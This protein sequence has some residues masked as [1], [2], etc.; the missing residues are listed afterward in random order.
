M[1]TAIVYGPAGASDNSYVTLAA[2]D[3]WFAASARAGQ[4]SGFS[5][6]ERTNALIEATRNI[7]SL[8]GPKDSMTARRARFGG[9]PAYF[10][11]GLHF[12]RGHDI[13]S[14]G[15]FIVPHGV[16][17]AVCEQA[18][19]LLQDNAAP[20]L[21]DHSA[22]QAAGIASKSVD[23]YS[24]TYRPGTTPYGIGLRAWNII[25]DYVSMTHGTC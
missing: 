25:R 2:A 16:R 24:V 13:D 10:T 14:G 6:D 17:D 7:E 8:G 12:P 19:Y 18:L 11:Q 21:E 9:E 23:G 5:M 15:H 1:S 20:A 3:E 22:N 4:W